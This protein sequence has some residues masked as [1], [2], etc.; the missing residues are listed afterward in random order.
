MNNIVY[1]DST[2]PSY[3]VDERE[4]L[5]T[6]TEVTRRWWMEERGR[7]TLRTT[8]ATVAELSQG[9]YPN[10]EK[11]LRSVEDVPLFP[12]HGRVIEVAQMYLDNYLMPQDLQGDALHLAYA[13]F[14]KAD[15]L[16]TWN[17]NHLANANKRRHIRVTNARLVLFVPEI[18]TPLELFSERGYE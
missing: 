1:L 5:K 15:F 7:F 14:Y 17:C 9:D 11:A 18:T 16:M 8:E 6:Y 3:L 13:S 10:K 12:P 2:V 4:S